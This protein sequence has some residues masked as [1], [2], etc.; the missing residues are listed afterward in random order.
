MTLNFLKTAFLLTL[1]ITAPSF[2]YAQEEAQES[3]SVPPLT[4]IQ[5]GDTDLQNP[6]LN[7]PNFAPS[8]TSTARSASSSG[9]GGSDI[10]TPANSPFDLGSDISGTIQNSINQVTGK[11]AFSVPLASIA[12]GTVSYGLS[13]GYDGQSAFKTGK[14]Q[15]KYSPTSVVGVGWSLPISKIVVDNKQTGTR[16]DDEFYIVGGATNSK[17]ICTKRGTN[18][19]GNVW[20]FQLEKHP[21]WIIKYHTGF[22]EFIDPP[23]PGGPRVVFRKSDYWS[24]VKEDGNTYYFGYATRTQNGVNAPTYSSQSKE[25]AASWGNWIG[26]SNKTPTG[27]STIVWNLS[28]ITDQWNNSINFK[29]ELAEQRQNTS[30]SAS[31]FKHTEA[32]YLKEITSSKGSKIQLNYA[33]K[34]PVAT[35]VSEYYEPHKEQQEPDAYQERYE[36]KYLQG[37]DVYNTKNQRISSYNLGSDLSTSSNGNQKRYLGSITQSS[38]L[39][40][41]TNA[42]P[43]QLFDYH[44]SGTYKGGLKKISY[45]SGGSV[46]YNYQNKTTFYNGEDRFKTTPVWPS[47][48]SFYSALVKD[49]YSL[50]IRRSINPVSGGKYRFKIFRNWWNGLQWESHEFTF[51][52]LIEDSSTEFMKNFYSVLGTDFYGFAYDRGSTADIYLFHKEKNGNSWNYFTRSGLNIGS[53]NPLR[54]LSG[55]KF[56]GLGSHKTGKLYTYVWNGRGWNS[57]QL[58]QGSG[59]YFYGATNNFI[60]SLDEEGGSDMVTGANHSDNY[61]VHYLDAENR[62]QTKSW[63]A[64]ADPYINDIWISE[65]RPGLASL[66]PANS[67]AG[68]VAKDNPELFLRWDTDYNLIAVDSKIGSYRDDGHYFVPVNNSMFTLVWHWFNQPAK[69]ARFN[70]INWKV[71]PFTKPTDFY[72]VNFGLDLMTYKNEDSDNIMYKEYSANSNSWVENNLN[73]A[74]Y[75]PYASNAVNSEFIVAGKKIYKKTFQ[76]PPVLPVL[77]IG[78]LQYDNDFSYSDGLSHTFVKQYNSNNEFKKSSYYYINKETGFLS[79][80]NLGSKYHLAGRE[81]IGGHTPFM[82]PKAIW[83]REDNSSTKFNTF[84]YRII[85]DKF[86]QSVYDIVVGS[87]DLDADD[88]AIRKVNYTYNNPRPSPDNNATYYGE[89]IVE[90]KGFGTSSIGKIKKLFHT[91]AEDVQLLGLPLEEQV[92][93][94]N[95]NLK[96]K[97]TNSWEKQLKTIYNTSS[98]AVGLSH[99]INLKSKKEEVFFNNYTVENLTT[100]SY[101]TKG[102]LASTYSTNSTGQ[103]EHQDIRYAHEQYPFMSAKNRLTDAYETTT[104]LNN[105]VVDL[106]RN[107]WV[108]VGGKVYVKEKWSGPSL[109]LLRLNNQVTN[110]DLQGNLLEIN[111]GK[112]IFSSSLRA[113]TDLYEVASVVNA[114]H[115]DVVN[116]LDVTYAQLQNLTTSA[117]K[118][119]LVKLYDRLPNAMISL[120]FYDDNGRV[121]NRINERKEESYLYY[122][123]YGRIDYITDGYGNLL[124][125]KEYNFGN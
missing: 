5:L 93:D 39:G 41:E 55:T 6:N 51:P 29:Y 20:E 14:E 24:I 36:K 68:L 74:A 9:G 114:K 27:V 53:D 34:N 28:R 107:I 7:D 89:V 37:V 63:S 58:N 85:D 84:L 65:S 32:S 56:V 71:S 81:K 48:Y 73:W 23:Y 2:G 112:N 45:P 17:L 60:L 95:N 109:S 69:A 26:D 98:Q 66:Y 59:Q 105:T 100:Y 43:P 102:Q 88:G 87:I 42:L 61:Y 122:D 101:T 18:S 3:Q 120:T 30:P 11:I 70:G 44:T 97:T 113:Y 76:A 125:K 10:G 91:G 54:F 103:T 86:N 124:E 96:S 119:E 82:S 118:G 72:H 12:S 115:Q 46:T 35:F 50:Y 64:A 104:K 108:H 1:F 40:G 123:S 110:V 67:I 77:N 19:N 4:D 57:K 49:N 38:H 121:T 31:S 13:I 80:I 21:N 62:W 78:T 117:L 47:G 92:L 90:N 116:E 99:Y 33:P 94:T 25:V 52:H 83:L 8:K 75:A 79:E 106:K 16:D 15:N 22:N 111:N